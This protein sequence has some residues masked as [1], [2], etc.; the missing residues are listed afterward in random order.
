[1]LCSKIVDNYPGKLQK[2]FYIGAI[3]SALW[4]A[5][6]SKAGITPVIATSN[7]QDD[8][9]GTLS[10]TAVDNIG[11]RASPR[12]T[13]NILSTYPQGTT[14]N[15]CTVNGRWAGIIVNPNLDCNITANYH[16]TKGYQGNCLQGWVDVNSLNVLIE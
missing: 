15:V 7:F 4:L 12:L 3:L 14:V 11:V 13:A 16:D 9:C 6:C 10:V 8:V 1:M 2:S 5:A